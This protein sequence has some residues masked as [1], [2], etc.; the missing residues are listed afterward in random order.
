MRNIH[1]H[2]HEIAA[3]ERFPHFDH[4]L[5]S[6]RAVGFVHAGS[7]DEHN[8]PTVF[9]FAL[10]NVDDALYAVARSL[11]LG[12]NDRQFLADKSVQQSGLAGVRPAKNAD[13]SGAEWHRS[14]EL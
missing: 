7:V 2:Q 6:Q 4:H 8:L 12:R 3:F 11:R 10:R 5:A 9:A 13:E 1:D 14:Y